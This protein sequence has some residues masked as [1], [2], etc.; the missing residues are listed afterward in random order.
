MESIDDEFGIHIDENLEQDEIDKI[1]IYIRK[2]YKKQISKKTKFQK[3]INLVILMK[4]KKT[5]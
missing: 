2:K 1:D 3:I 4:Q 5:I